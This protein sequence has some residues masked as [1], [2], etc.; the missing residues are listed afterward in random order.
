MIEIRVE[1]EIHA[2]QERCFDLAR[3]LSMH[4]VT[5]GKTRERIVSTHPSD[6]LELGDEVTFEA[7]H[8]GVRQRLTSRIV[9]FER[10]NRFV[11]Q[12]QK[13]A[14]RSLRHEHLFEKIDDESTKMIDILQF[15]SPLGP[16]GGLVDRLFLRSYM[17]QFIRGRGQAMKAVT[18]ATNPPQEL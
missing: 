12:M 5:T 18:E 7:T 11:D 9:E 6:L 14:F 3:S 2:S 13:G 10:P 4:V 16:L 1:T 8:F 17:E 15:E